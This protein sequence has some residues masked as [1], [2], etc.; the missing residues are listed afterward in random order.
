MWRTWSVYHRQCGKHTLPTGVFKRKN[1]SV[2]TEKSVFWLISITILKPAVLSNGSSTTSTFKTDISS[3]S[4]YCFI[5]QNSCE[6]VPQDWWITKACNFRA[7][8]IN[9]LCKVLP[10]APS[11]SIKTEREREISVIAMVDYVPSYRSWK[12]ITAVQYSWIPRHWIPRIL[13]ISNDLMFWIWL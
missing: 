11:I 5:T 1:V 8:L 2:F 7:L 6:P 4:S 13:D 9:D 12:I 3:G 10:N